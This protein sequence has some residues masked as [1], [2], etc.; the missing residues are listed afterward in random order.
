MLQVLREG[1]DKGE[2]PT[3]P[4]GPFPLPKQADAVVK[5]STMPADHANYA[6][7]WGA[8]AAAMGVLA[9]RLVRRGK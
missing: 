4:G 5:F 9:V 6:A 7:M 8:M 3:T 2:A 1:R